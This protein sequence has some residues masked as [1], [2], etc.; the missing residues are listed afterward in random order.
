MAGLKKFKNDI[1]G[2]KLLKNNLIFLILILLSAFFAFAAEESPC[3]TLRFSTDCGLS[4]NTLLSVRI[5]G[6]ILGLI[7]F[8][9]FFKFWMGLKFPWTSLAWFTFGLG[10]AFA[11]R[12]IKL[13]AWPSPLST[14]E[15]AS[16][17][18]EVFTGTFF[19]LGAYR[20]YKS[21]K[22]V[23]WKTIIP[24][25][26]LLAVVG[27]TIVTIRQV[28]GQEIIKL[29]NI[30]LTSFWLFTF[31]MATLFA[32]YVYTS[33][34][35]GVALW[36]AIALFMFVLAS[37]YRLVVVKTPQVLWFLCAACTLEV[38]SFPLFLV[39]LRKLSKE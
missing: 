12:A 9:L 19:V 5:S 10:T 24:P 31:S 6:F 29:T 11:V 17:M 15:F 4:Y 26:I 16:N 30:I 1:H 13:F 2:K 36:L 38:L 27:L 20:L 34:N 37:L 28:E 7:T 14:P 23:E 3:K 22:Q 32:F 35:K 21:H 8:I 39:A 33:T 18:L 25:L